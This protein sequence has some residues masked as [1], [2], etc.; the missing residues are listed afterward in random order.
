MVNK[1]PEGEE[2]VNFLMECRINFK[3]FCDNVLS[4]IFMEKYGGLQPYMEEWFN[5]IQENSRVGIFAARGYAKTT[6]LGVAYPLWLAFTKKNKAILVVSR[7]EAQ[8]KRVLAVIKVAIEQNP[9]LVE[10]K[11]KEA[12]DTWSSKQ[13]NTTTGCKIY[14]R[15]FTKSILGERTDFVLMDEADSYDYPENYFDY[16]VPTLNPGGKIALISTPNTGASLM[17]MIQERNLKEQSGYIMRTYP[18]MVDGESIWSSRFPAKCSCK[19]SCACETLENKRK[20]LGE[21]LFQ[22]NFMCNPVAE[23]GRS[24]YTAQS[25][26]DCSD[27]NSTFTEK[28]YGGDIFIGCDFATATGPTAD[29]DCYTVVERNGDTGVIRFAEFHRTPDVG[30]KV[31]RIIELY[32]RYDAQVVICDES[33]IGVA[34]LAELRGEGIST[35]AQSFQ[36]RARNKLLTNLKTLLDHGN[37]KI[38]RS[39]EDLQTSKYSQRLEIE[40]LSFHEIKTLSGLTTYR[41]VGAHDD[42]AVSLAMAVKHIQIKKVFEDY[43]GVA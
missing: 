23:S 22:K 32:E 20:E 12:R 28:G 33:S 35:E 5:L 2:L 29:F 34:V 43:I 1:I 27:W 26:N 36:S 9:L 18:A 7:S 24:I 40:L 17:S 11:P 4:D 3:F 42:T 39:P 8:A 14:C 41:S 30:A 19:K 13:I 31:A 15:P 37:L 21:Q 16:V 6:I 38:P 25:I 10:L